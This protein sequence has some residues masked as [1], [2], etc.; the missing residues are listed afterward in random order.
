MT[1]SSQLTLDETTVL[2]RGVHAL[3]GFAI[4]FGC[5]VLLALRQEDVAAAILNQGRKFCRSVGG[6]GF[7]GLVVLLG[8][9]LDPRQTQAGNGHQ[10]RVLAA[11]NQPLQRGLTLVCL[12]VLDGHLGHHQGTLL[13]ECGAGVLALEICKSLDGLVG[14]A[15]TGCTVQLLI[16]ATGTHGALLLPV[17]VAR[18]GGVSTQHQHQHPGDQVA[19]LLP[20]VL[21]LVKLFL[22]FKIVGRH[23]GSRFV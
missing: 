8:V 17:Q 10:V 7:Q 4:G 14:I 3:P 20:E 6:Q 22:L 9:H 11:I 15:S 5:V 1:Q 2:H 21:D 12:L 18:P 13:G 16:Q 19:I 23:D